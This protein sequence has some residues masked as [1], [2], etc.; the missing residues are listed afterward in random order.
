MPEGLMRQGKKKK[1]IYG[2]LVHFIG[3][4]ID[5]LRFCSLCL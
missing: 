4:L 2:A 5:S 1:K 3:G